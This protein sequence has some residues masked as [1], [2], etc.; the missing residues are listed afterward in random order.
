MRLEGREGSQSRHISR[1]A[2]PAHNWRGYLPDAWAEQVEAPLWV[3]EFE[4]YQLDAQRWI[5]YDADEQPCYTAHH[6]ALP[7]Q[8]NP[9]NPA[10]VAYSE[11]LAAW[12]L[13]DE[14]W[15]VFRLIGTGSTVLPRG[16]YLISPDMPR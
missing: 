13:R 7:A 2:I 12:R 3:D 9:E 15:L 5:G 16:F 1:E 4:E 8:R 14:R 6:Y 11:V 10:E